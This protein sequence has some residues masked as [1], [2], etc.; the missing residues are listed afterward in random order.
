MVPEEVW[1]HF[2]PRLSTSCISLDSRETFNAPDEDTSGLSPGDRQKLEKIA[3]LFE[4]FKSP[5]QV[6]AGRRSDVRDRINVSS[7]GPLPP[8]K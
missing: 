5:L 6:P 1:G 2:V 3:N 7:R 4:A 8:V